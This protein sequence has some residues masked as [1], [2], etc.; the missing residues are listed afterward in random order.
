MIE[1]FDAAIADARRR[2]AARDFR[3]AEQALDRARGI[4]AA[5]PS[6]TEIALR[7]SEQSRA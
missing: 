1:Q 7:L 2:L 5:A 6:V 3:G 4:D